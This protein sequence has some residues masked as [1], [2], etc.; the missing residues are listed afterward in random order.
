MKPLR[1][2]VISSLP[3]PDW[4][5]QGKRT[6]RR[7][8]PPRLQPSSGGAPNR[9]AQAPAGSACLFLT[10]T[11]QPSLPPGPDA[12]TRSSGKRRRSPSGTWGSGSFYIVIFAFLCL[13]HLVTTAGTARISHIPRPGPMPRTGRSAGL[14]RP[15][16]AGSSIAGGAPA[17]KGL[18][19]RPPAAPTAQDK[20]DG[21]EGPSRQLGHGSERLR[22]A[23]HTHTHP[24]PKAQ[25]HSPE[26]TRKGGRSA[27]LEKVDPG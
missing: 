3:N 17:A 2:F 24:L 22:P 19:A 26:P 12:K 13:N 10:A 6:S 11:I 8:G 9:E 5:L 21:T 27:G 1:L 23:T 14:H 7:L 18:P 16:S 25:T 4:I 15:A 20:A